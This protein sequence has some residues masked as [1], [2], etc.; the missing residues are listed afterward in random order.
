MEN[1]LNLAD[2]PDGLGLSAWPSGPAS[3]IVFTNARMTLELGQIESFQGLISF[4][5]N[6]GGLVPWHHGN[7]SLL[8][9]RGW[10]RSSARLYIKSLTPSRSIR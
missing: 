8:F 6:F 10:L 3:L 1:K 4:N 7:S 2:L 9:E 5:H